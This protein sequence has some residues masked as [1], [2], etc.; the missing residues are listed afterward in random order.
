MTRGESFKLRPFVYY[1]RPLK[2]IDDD[3][4]VRGHIDHAPFVAGK[5]VAQA[6]WSAAFVVRLPQVPDEV[7]GLDLHSKGAS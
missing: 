4:T 7:S 5:E 6:R 3:R 1:G 2:P